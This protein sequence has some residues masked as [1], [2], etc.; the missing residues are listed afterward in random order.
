MTKTSSFEPVKLSPLACVIL[1]AGQ[2]TRMRS[3]LPKVMHPV[4]GEPMIRHVVATC[5]DSHAD[6]IIVVI[7]PDM[8]SAE[9]VLRPHKCVVQKIPLGTGDAVKAA[10]DELKNFNGDI[11]VLFGDTPLVTAEALQSL[12][13]VRK[14][15]GASIVVGANTPSDPAAY[16]RIVLDKS[17]QLSSI[18]EV[19]DATPEQLAIKLCNGG[20]MLFEAGKLWPLLD[21]LRNDNAKKEFYLTDCVKLARDAGL[22]CAVAEMDS[23]DVMGINTREELAQ[24]EKLMQRRLRKRAML[25]G[26]TMTDPDT[27]YLCADTAFG[28][29]VVIGP[30]VV[31]APGVEIADNVQIRPFCHLEQARVKSGAVIGPFAR[32]RPGTVVGEGAHVGN[33]VEI[34][35]SEVCEGAKVNH[36]TY[37]GDA[38]IGPKANIGAGTITCN[39]DGFNKSKTHIGAGAF[40]GSNSSL[41]APVKIGDGAVVGAGSVV[42]K[43]VEKDSLAVSRGRQ[44]NYEGWAKKF[45]EIHKHKK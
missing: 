16:G 15:T 36:L 19:K 13:R 8:K 1:A 33:F 22:S 7:S 2:G 29:D 9:D 31:F 40:I 20:I 5:A 18:V 24:A 23:E 3:E 45:R 27:V 17:G 11:I 34:K 28:Q 12:R 38:Y 39:Y 25:A 6:R 30:N 10:R 21:K 44:A 4:A 32:L 41:V 37:I 43:E 14:D 26:V 42:N 35:N